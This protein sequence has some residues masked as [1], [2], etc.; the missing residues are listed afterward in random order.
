M[1]GAMC[2]SRVKESHRLVFDQW[3]RAFLGLFVA[4]LGLTVFLLGGTAR[5]ESTSEYGPPLSNRT[6]TQPF[7]CY[8]CVGNG[9]YHTGTDYG[10]N[11]RIEAVADGQVV[12]TVSNGED[13]DGLGNTVILKH[14]NEDGSTIYSMYSHLDSIAVREEG[15][16]EKGG[17][18]GN[19]GG[20]GYGDPSYY[21]KH[22]HFEMKTGAVLRNPSGSGLHLK[23]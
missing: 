20:S 1:A 13:D 11:S 22:L 7:N 2:C 14:L 15:C 17:H 21:D 19:M 3:A 5:A 6:V 12:K 10:G 9:K 4:V 23:M 16:L 18:V 8:D